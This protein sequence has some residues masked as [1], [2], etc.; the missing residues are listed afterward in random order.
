MAS[1]LILDKVLPVS[2]LSSILDRDLWAS[3]FFFLSISFFEQGFYILYIMCKGIRQ[4][5]TQ[6]LYTLT[7]KN[8]K[9]HYDTIFFVEF[10]KW[11]WHAMLFYRKYGFG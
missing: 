4:K 2:F 6:L 11:L 7:I 8:I 3:W 5:I 10:L 9:M 1:V